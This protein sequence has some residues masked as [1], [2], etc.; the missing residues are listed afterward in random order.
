MDYYYINGTFNNY[1]IYS[2]R[3]DFDLDCLGFLKVIILC[4]TI[5]T[6][7]ASKSISSPPAYLRKI[8]YMH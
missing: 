3:K 5:L 6:L 7:Q 2:F 4:I 1:V 8:V